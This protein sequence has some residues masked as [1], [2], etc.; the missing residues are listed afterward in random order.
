MG[1]KG[2]KEAV[3]TKQQ[4]DGVADLIGGSEPQVAAGKAQVS[5]KI[6]KG[7]KEA[8]ETSATDELTFD[9][10]MES[11]RAEILTAEDVDLI[12]NPVDE[13]GATEETV[14]AEATT[15]VEATTEDTESSES[16][17]LTDT[18]MDG[19]YKRRDAMESGHKELEKK[20]TQ[21]SQ[22]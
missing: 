12:E 15:E 9:G 20:L 10:V 17:D 3:A 11:S 13:T 14:S 1:N 2:K 19:R 8:A 16:T 6:Y 18:F 21:T 4:S 7:P 22:E 5:R